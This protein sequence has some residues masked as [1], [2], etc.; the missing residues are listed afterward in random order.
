M[1]FFRFTW[2]P[3][4]SLDP[5]SHISHCSVSSLA[6]SGS[7]KVEA[8]SLQVSLTVKGW[9]HI[10][11]SSAP[12]TSLQLPWP[13]SLMPIVKNNFRFF[14]LESVYCTQYSW[15]SP[16]LGTLLSFLTWQFS[17][18][19]FLPLSFHLWSYCG[20]ILPALKLGGH[21]PGTFLLIQCSP[22][23]PGSF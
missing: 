20:L 3:A 17:L 4:P 19:W 12:L 16:F 14:I 10:N 23:C 2:G 11:Q 1:T 21:V 5:N 22:P 6:Q 15:Y 13:R 7:W 9:T 18:F 8:H